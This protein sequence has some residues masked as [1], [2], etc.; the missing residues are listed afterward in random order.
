MLALTIQT[1]IVG[2]GAY[3]ILCNDVATA[4]F[5]TPAE[6]AWAV[7]RLA[8][9]KPKGYNPD[10]TDADSFSWR[11][12]RQGLF[13]LQ[14][15]LSALSFFSILSALYSFGLFV[16]TSTSSSSVLAAADHTCSHQGSRLHCRR[17]AALLGAAVRDGVRVD[18][19]HRGPFGSDE[20]TRTLHALHPSHLHHRLRPHPHHH[21]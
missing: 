5:L 7:Q 9:D 11:R 21:L 12:V 1:I 8:N 20:A 2:A 17:G 13:S 19:V 16:P 18:V 4:P 3:F 14:L 6:Q 15:W 10:G